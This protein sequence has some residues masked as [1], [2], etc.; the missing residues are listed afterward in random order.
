MTSRL[1]PS[2]P[3]GIRRLNV[4]CGPFHHPSDWWNV[5][6]RPF[7]GV[8]EILDVTKTFPW[9][10]LEFVYCEHFIEHLALDDALRFLE[11]AGRA[12]R[13]GG[14]LRISTPNL[15]YVHATHFRM[16]PTVPPADR[17][18]DTLAMNCAF[19]GWGHQFLYTLEMLRYLLQE[20]GFAGL[21]SCAFGE[22][23]HPELAGCEKHTSDYEVAGGLPSV[24]IVEATRAP[25]RI[26]PSA[27][28]IELLETRFLSHVRAGH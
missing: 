28:L 19:H 2:S 26:A 18:S 15:E 9:S 1:G 21:E 11:N 23:R 17:V 25:G 3:G 20:V 4:G 16:G 22:S 14:V 8:D 7:P 24:V 13:P 10:D 27:K 5:D 6:L 12:L